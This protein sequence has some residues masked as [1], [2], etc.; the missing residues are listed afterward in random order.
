MVIPTL[1]AAARIPFCLDRLARQN[2]VAEII[3]VDR[4]SI[5]DTTWIVGVYAV[6]SEKVQLLTTPHRVD[7]VT[8][9]NLGFDAASADIIGHLDVDTRVAPQWGSAISRHMS[10]HPDSAALTGINTYQ[11]RFRAEPTSFD[12]GVGAGPEP[13][14]DSALLVAWANIAIRRSAWL[15]VRDDTEATTAAH[16]D[17]GLAECLSKRGRRIDRLVPVH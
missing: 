2:A 16:T 4:G 11:P 3:V 8:A 1:D 13:D 9:R 7:L 15:E 17:R 12:T 6:L 5:D 10:E 14:E